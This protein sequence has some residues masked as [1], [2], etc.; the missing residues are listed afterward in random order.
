MFSDAN[1]AT[2]RVYRGRDLA[3]VRFRA[4]VP[5]P[6]PV[7]DTTVPRN[8]AIW[9]KRHRSRPALPPVIYF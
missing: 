2:L 6:V 7:R 3:R 1:G 9:T 4:R 5:I 8:T